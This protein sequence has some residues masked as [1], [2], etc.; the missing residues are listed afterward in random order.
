MFLP[1]FC[2][3]QYLRSGN[4]IGMGEWKHCVYRMGLEVMKRKVMMSKACHKRLCHASGSKLSQV[5]FFRKFFLQI[6]AQSM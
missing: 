5:D 6:K 1:T 3:V 4:L 2:F